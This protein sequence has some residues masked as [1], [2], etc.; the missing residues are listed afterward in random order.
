MKRVLNIASIVA[1][2]LGVILIATVVGRKQGLGSSAGFSG[3][4][5]NQTRQIDIGASDDAMRQLSRREFSDQ[6]KDWLLT[7]IVSDAGLTPAELNQALFDLPPVRYEYLHPVGSFEYGDTRSRSIGNGRLVALIPKS[8]EAAR[9]DALARVADDA[10]KNT[11]DKPSQVLVF[12]YEIAP[13]GLSADVTRRADLDGASLFSEANG[14]FETTVANLDDMRQFM[15]HIAD[16]TFA[17]LDSAGLR[18][19]GRKV[20]GHRHHNIRV[21]DVAAL[22]S[23]QSNLKAKNAQFENFVQQKQREFNERWRYNSINLSFIKS[24]RNIDLARVKAEIAR[25]R[26]RLGAVAHTGFSLDPSFVHSKVKSELNGQLGLLILIGAKG[27]LSP[28]DIEQAAMMAGDGDMDPFYA[29]LEKLDPEFARSV[30]Q[31]LKKRCAYQAARYDGD[32]KGTEAGMVLFYTDLLAKLWA[33]DYISSAPDKR[34]PDFISM[35]HIVVSPI[36]NREMDVL[37]STRLWFGVQSRGFALKD[38][39]APSLLLAPVATRLYA[40]SSDSITPG[41]E[42][43]P[44]PA[45][46]AFLG[47]WDD[48]FAEVARFEPEY[49]RLNQ[50]M[51]WSILISWLDEKGQLDKLSVLK[52]VR[53]ETDNWFPEWVTKHLDLRFKNWEQIHFYPRG[54]AKT[55]ALPLLRSDTRLPMPLLGGV[56]LAEKEVIEARGAISKD[57]AEFGRRPTLKWSETTPDVFKTIEGAEYKFANSAE[58]YTLD[59]TLNAGTKFRAAESEVAGLRYSRTIAFDNTGVRMQAENAG[60]AIGELRIERTANSFRIAWQSR[61]FDAGTSLARKVSTAAD[62]ASA[63]ASDP[64]VAA[65]IQ[66]GDNEFLVKLNGSSRWLKL[67]PER[68]PSA[69]IAAGWQ[70]RVAPVDPHAKSID[71]A[72]Y[73]G[74]QALPELSGTKYLRV[75]GGSPQAEGVRMQLAARPPPEAVDTEVRVAGKSFRAQRD[76]ATGDYY[77][78]LSELPPEIRENPGLLGGSRG[79]GAPP[80]DEL[81]GGDFRLAANKMVH[82]PL[83]FKLALDR[84]YVSG[85]KQVDQLLAQGD[86]AKALRLLDDLSAVHGNT[87]EI[88]L[89]K[90][91]A[92]THAGDNGRA[93]RALNATIKAPIRDRSALFDEINAR[94]RNSGSDAERDDLLQLAAFGDWSDMRNT[95]TLRHGVP[96]ANVDRGRLEIEY[97]ATGG[98][99]GTRVSDLPSGDVPIYIQDTP[100]LSNLDSPAAIEQALHG[101]VQGRLPVVIRFSE[102]D[103]AR[104]RPAKIYS[105]ED[106]TSFRK[107]ESSGSRTA[108]NAYRAYSNQPCQPNDP[109]AEC[110][111]QR[112]P[113][114]V[115]VDSRD[116]AQLN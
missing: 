59:A 76:A 84:H 94:I 5:V 74:D 99:K 82:D 30:V 55:E 90:A 58:R 56:S 69:D 98:L 85:L 106:K 97:H 22:W 80:F 61:E 81:A 110:Q 3:F 9:F 109:R 50:I 52:D 47:W 102:E 73:S 8:D 28:T 7:T 13:D 62:P 95:G 42:V 17:R 34:I 71:I 20:H 18:L 53:F 23:A 14:Y 103:V 88:A 6:I 72:W 15:S 36:Y 104:F 75:S 49:E 93:A 19:G 25:E 63:I 10:R 70:S 114:Y 41:K 32:L 92:L 48:H 44:N 87:P 68:Q 96:V 64:R 101:G 79:S 115:I 112:Q 43:A 40:A 91:V 51:K 105:P 11:G 57:V 111:S 26:E 113:V 77:V 100:G 31:E 4:P 37:P 29:M 83:A 86:D 12:E 66:T 39:D 21:Q 60:T 116:A 108:N 54:Y 27:K 2:I 65:S 67:A 38:G 45:S 78:R 1:A 16:L 24:E 33:L 107:V 89:R 46:A 35:S